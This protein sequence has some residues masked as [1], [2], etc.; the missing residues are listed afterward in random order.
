VSRAKKKP[1]TPAERASRAADLVV[2]QLPARHAAFVA[3]HGEEPIFL[4]AAPDCA[5]GAKIVADYFGP[6]V[7]AALT[8]PIVLAF[9]R[10]E[11]LAIFRGPDIAPMTE[12]VDS[13]VVEPEWPWRAVFAC[14]GG[15]LEVRRLRQPPPMTALPSVRPAT[16]TTNAPN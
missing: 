7:L 16:S 15:T 10:E 13:L 11:L 9:T 2:G 12:L 6:A 8:G 4:V 3:Q 14:T 1:T 5:L